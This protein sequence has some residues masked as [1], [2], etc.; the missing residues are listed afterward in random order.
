LIALEVCDD[1]GWW[2][3][4]GGLVICNHDGHAMGRLVGLGLSSAHLGVAGNINGV[5]RVVGNNWLRLGVGNGGP[6]SRKGISCSSWSSSYGYLSERLV[7][8]DHE[9]ATYHVPRTRC[10][11]RELSTRPPTPPLRPPTRPHSRPTLWGYC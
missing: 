2:V 5:V 3:V 7:K 11:F 6:A 8:M 10:W 4:E 1:V 9:K